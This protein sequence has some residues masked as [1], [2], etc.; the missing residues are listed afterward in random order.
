ME[1]NYALLGKRLKAL[2]VEKKLTQERLAELTDVSPQHISHIETNSSKVSLPA[3]VKICN[4]LEVTPDSILLDSISS[5]TPQLV[6]EIEAAFADCTPDEVY[7]MLSQA[8][9]LKRALR[10]KQMFIPRTD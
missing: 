6:G 7:L 10:A 5:S 9:N 3:L 8:I 1:L 2:R 4:A